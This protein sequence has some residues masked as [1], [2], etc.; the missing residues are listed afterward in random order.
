[1][2]EN[3]EEVKFLAIKLINSSDFFELLLRLL[4][5]TFV[6]YLI[7]NRVYLKNNQNYQF[8]FSYNTIA[9]VTFLTSFLLNSVKLELGFALGLFALFTMIRFRTG[10]IPI[11]EM[12]YLFVVIGVAVINALANKKVSYLEL[13]FANSA[14]VFAVNYFENISSRVKSEKKRNGLCKIAKIWFI[15]FLT[16]CSKEET[17]WTTCQQT[18]HPFQSQKS[19]SVGKYRWTNDLH[20]ARGL[21]FQFWF[22]YLRFVIL[23]CTLFSQLQLFAQDESVSAEDNQS[24]ESWNALQ[25]QYEPTEKLSLTLEAQLRL[26]SVG[27][28]YNM[29]FVE[30]QAIYDLQPFLDLGVGYRNFDRLDDVGKK[31]GHEQY[32]RFFGFAQVKTEFDQFVLRFRVQHQVKTQ[33][34]VTDQPKDNSRWRY[35]LSSRY[36]I[37]NWDID[38]RLSIEF[39]MLDEFYSNEAYDKFRLSIGSKKRFSNTNA[40]SFKYQY[41][42]K[43]GTSEPASFHILSL[44][45]SFYSNPKQNNFYTLYLLNLTYTT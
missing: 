2:I 45:T 39:F 37:S 30:A 12:T 35:K 24:F 26:K 28:T 19:K 32:N 9:I 10:T 18:C 4:L 14:I 43:V 22:M 7:S 11:K 33:R 13:L 21:N 44:D 36:N 29:S 3:I 42:K 25:L 8:Y 41:E 17:S 20:Q 15:F 5:N 6:V 38:P 31:Q 23:L 16:T 40:L 27:E 1:M 34:Y